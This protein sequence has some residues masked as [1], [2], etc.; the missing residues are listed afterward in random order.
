MIYRWPDKRFLG[1]PLH[2]AAFEDFRRAYPEYDRI[3]LH[4]FSVQ[5]ELIE[6][7]LSDPRWTVE[8]EGT[9][10]AGRRYLVLAPVEEA[11]L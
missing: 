7:L 11:G 10:R 3:L 4:D 9:N 8:R 2:P 6:S 1:M 5:D